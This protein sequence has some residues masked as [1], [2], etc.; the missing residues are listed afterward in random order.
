VN[1]DDHDARMG[2][3]QDRD[4]QSLAPVVSLSVGDACTFRFGN[5][6]SR[7]KPYVDVSLR[8]GSLFVFGGPS[9]L[10]FHGVTKIHPATAPTGCGLKRGRINITLRVTGLSERQAG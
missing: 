1:Y 8:S 5:N 9:R 4:E 7:R 6:K 2:T 10:A 3:R